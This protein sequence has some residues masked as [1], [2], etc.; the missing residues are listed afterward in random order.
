[1][2]AF[3]GSASIVLP[4]KSS[5]NALDA[6]GSAVIKSYQIGVPWGLG[7]GRLLSGVGIED[8]HEAAEDH[9]LAVEGHR[10]VAHCGVFHDPGHARVEGL[11]VGPFDPRADD[12]LVLSGVDPPLAGGDRKSCR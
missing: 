5:E 10:R 8:R 12:V 3:A 11:L 7:I 6:A 9:A 2:P 4:I 1:M